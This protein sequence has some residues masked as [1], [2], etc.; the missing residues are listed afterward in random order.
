[1]PTYSITPSA[2]P[3]KCPLSAHHPVTTTPNP[4][5]LPLPL[6]HFPDLG[7]SCFV[8]L[9]DI[10]TP[11]LWVLLAC[12]L[13]FLRSPDEANG[14]YLSFLMAEEYSIVYIN[15]ILFIHS[16][17]DGHRGSFHSLAIVDIAA[18]NIGVQVSR[19]FIASVSSG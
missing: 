19:R 11:F 18:R 4:L 5:P 1:M 12:I 7:V 9:N 6:V 2:H 14:G 15:H 13:S 3:A 17:L 8:T 16:C 10:F